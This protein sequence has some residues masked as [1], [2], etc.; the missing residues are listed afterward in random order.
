MEQTNGEGIKVGSFHFNSYEDV[1]A[2][3]LENLQED[4]YAFGI[5]LDCI[6]VCEL[7]CDTKRDGAD[8]AKQISSATG[9][10]LA[11]FNE[12]KALASF[13]HGIPTIFDGTADAPLPKL[14]KPEKWENLQRYEPGLKSQIKDFMKV[15][16]TKTLEVS[17]NKTK[18]VK[19]RELAG[20]MKMA[21]IEWWNAYC[22]NLSLTHSDLTTRAGL[23]IIESWDFATN[24]ARRILVEVNGPRLVALDVGARLKSNRAEVCSIVLFGMLKCHK[25]M[26]QFK[27][28]DFK[29]HPSIGSERIK[30]LFNNLSVGATGGGGSAAGLTAVKNKADSALTAARTAQSLADAAKGK[31]ET[32]ER[33]LEALTKVVDKK[34]DK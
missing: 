27:E 30:L 25:V 1:N 8:M 9:A 31:S 34:K 3:V 21:T 32:L 4:D 7:M 16:L 11:S 24:E 20:L 13:R 17:I 23:S 29:D 10:G 15:G 2:W 12:A 33:K 22:D 14:A 5:F 26:Q 6:S 19:A 18:N 28:H